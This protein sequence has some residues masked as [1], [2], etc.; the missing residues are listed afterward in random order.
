MCRYAR[1]GVPIHIVTATRGE[2][3]ALGANG[4]T[5]T[6]EELPAIRERELRDALARYG[7]NPPTFLGYRDA[8]VKDAD[9]RELVA[10]VKAEMLRVKPTATITFGPHG[11]SKHPDHTTLHK[12]VLEAFHAYRKEAG[13]EAALL[14]VAL[15]GERV[16]K[17]ELDLDGPET[18]PNITIDITLDFQ[19]KLW[20]LRNYRSQED[21]QFL[22]KMFEERDVRQEFFHQAYPPLPPGVMKHG[23][24]E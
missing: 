8:E 9:Y 3:G 1:E 19:T 13:I 5:Y 18:Q 12:A 17:F 14:Y 22:A 15:P 20:G 24:W 16:R 10:K 23:F 6:R 2:Q 21:A 11:I 4:V 7:V